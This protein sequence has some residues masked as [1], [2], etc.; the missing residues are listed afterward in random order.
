MA[1][2]I[3]PTMLMPADDLPKVSCHWHETKDGD[4]RALELYR[5]HYT[6]RAYADG[7]NPTL[8]VGP[9]Y[10]MV[11]LTSTADALFVWRKFRSMDTV[12]GHGVNCAVFRNEG[13]VLSSILIQ[14]AVQLAWR[15]WPNERLYTYVNSKKVKSANAGYCYKCAGWR[16]VGETKSGLL[17]FEVNAR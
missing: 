15:R 5:R 7:R 14:E 13:S 6:Y 12:F 8:F 4:T 16:K 1:L 11:L 3:Q 10:K 17:V 9:G 2:L